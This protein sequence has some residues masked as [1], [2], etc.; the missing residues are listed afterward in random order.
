MK[1][2]FPILLMVTTSFTGAAWAQGETT[3]WMCK[4]NGLERRVELNESM[5]EA[6]VCDVWYDKSAEG[7]AK[8]RLW[9]ADND[10]EYCRPKA[11]QLVE[12]LTSWGWTCEAMAAE[13]QTP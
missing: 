4:V 8:M 11:E 2:I 12:S 10:G 7:G 1:K 13:D 5:T 3:T 6:P 9:S